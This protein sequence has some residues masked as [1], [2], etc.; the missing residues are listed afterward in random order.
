MTPCSI[1]IEQHNSGHPNPQSAQ[2][3]AGWT[4]GISLNSEYYYKIH[5]VCFIRGQGLPWGPECLLALRVCLLRLP[6][7]LLQAQSLCQFLCVVPPVPSPGKFSKRY[8]CYVTVMSVITWWWTCFV[9]LCK[10][11]KT[12]SQLTRTS[13]GSITMMIDLILII[14]Y[15]NL[16]WST[17]ALFL[18]Y[19]QLIN[20]KLNF[21]TLIMHF[22]I[23][24][25]CNGNTHIPGNVWE[26][27]LQ[28]SNVMQN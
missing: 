24:H 18:W 3:S 7:D 11:S 23:S 1:K 19:L 14:L 27:T 4:A 9:F 6:S 12:F 13:N 21:T 26:T 5:C 16:S 10:L 2:W 15:I 20:N 28:F 25:S 22:S 17:I 8:I